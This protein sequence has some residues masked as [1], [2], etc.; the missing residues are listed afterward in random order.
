MQATVKIYSTF[1]VIIITVLDVCGNL[2]FWNHCENIY[3]RK[4]FDE[5]SYAIASEIAKHM[6]KNNIT[7]VNVI[8]KGPNFGISS[9]LKALKANKI[10]I[11]LIKDITPI[12]HN[13]AF[14]IKIRK[15]LK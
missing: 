12:P 7:N 11:N 4:N 2:L 15:R 6:Y 3:G 9:S 14:P 13:G 5:A 1:N 10:N 8:I